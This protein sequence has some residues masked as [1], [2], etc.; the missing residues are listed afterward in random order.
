LSVL[1][2]AVHTLLLDRITIWINYTYC[3][4]DCDNNANAH[5]DD[6]KSSINIEG[7][8]SNTRINTGKSKHTSNWTHSTT[9][10]RPEWLLQ[11]N[12]NPQ[13]AP[14]I[15]IYDA[16]QYVRS[17]R[18]WNG[19]VLLLHEFCHIIHQF[20]LQ[21]GLDNGAIQEMHQ[22]ALLQLQ[23]QQQCNINNTETKPKPSQYQCVIRRDWLF[24]DR[25]SV[26]HD[27]TNENIIA[28]DD[29]QKRGRGNDGNNQRKEEVLV[30]SSRP[31]TAGNHCTPAEDDERS[32]LLLRANNT[33]RHRSRNNADD[34]DLNLKEGTSNFTFTDVSYALVNE[35]EFFAELSVAFLCDSYHHL[36]IVPFPLLPLPLTTLGRDDDATTTTT[37]KQ[38]S[39]SKEQY[40][41]CIKES[42]SPPLPP[43]TKGNYFEFRSL[44]LLLGSIATG[45][46]S[47]WTKLMQCVSSCCCCHGAAEAQH[48]QR[49][50]TARATPLSFW[51]HCNK[52]YPFTRHQ[53]AAFDAEAFALLQELWKSVESWNGNCVQSS[54]NTN[55]TTRQYHDH[56]YYVATTMNM[57][58][59]TV[60]F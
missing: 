33:T 26:L 18:Y 10:H 47:L 20:V 42:I 44:T 38:Y 32:A 19:Y 13:K 3:D 15:E 23:Q 1:P 51:W 25:V 56:E 28:A 52:F 12:D 40:R 22:K 9:H 8:N 4:C 49:D 54:T 58:S 21:D 45:A 55:T 2:R 39:C 27:T 17:R 37:T 11:H 7:G 48:S 34:C 31:T 29:Q 14:G 53:L 35:R 41:Y 50:G 60:D 30:S 24:G 16:R 36:D 6:E 59:D 57:Y 43:P 46:Q 5:G